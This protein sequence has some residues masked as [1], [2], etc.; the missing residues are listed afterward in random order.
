MKNTIV[1]ATRF[2]KLL[3]DYDE[4]LWNRCRVHNKL[5]AIT[6]V[7]V[8]KLDYVLSETGYDNILKWTKS[9][10]PKGNTLKDNFYVAKSMKEPLVLRYAKIGMC[11]NFFMLYNNKYKNFIEYKTCQHNRYKLNNE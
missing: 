7:F 6:Q 10:L 11:P 5:S 4:P 1:D 9:I 8:I 3:E 2:F